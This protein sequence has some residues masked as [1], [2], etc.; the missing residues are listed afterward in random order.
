[1]KEHVTHPSRGVHQVSN[2]RNGRTTS[3][4]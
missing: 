3:L 4:L 2:T 1:M